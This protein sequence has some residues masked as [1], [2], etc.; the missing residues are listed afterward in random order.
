MQILFSLLTEGL[1]LYCFAKFHPF[2]I[3][4][5]RASGVQSRLKSA[6]VGSG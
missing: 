4:D 5:V 3:I 1:T 6:Q 2:A